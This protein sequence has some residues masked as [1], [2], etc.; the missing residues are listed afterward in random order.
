MKTCFQ[1]LYRKVSFLRFP[2]QC[3]CIQ[4]H[5]HLIQHVLFNK[6]FFFT[7]LHIRIVYFKPYFYVATPVNPTQPFIPQ[8]T[9]LYYFSATQFFFESQ[10]SSNE[11][12][13]EMLILN[14]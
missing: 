14:P 2:P 11:L 7:I 4:I 9:T 1:C 6:H 5:L 3:M 10:S 8:D 12:T 13:N